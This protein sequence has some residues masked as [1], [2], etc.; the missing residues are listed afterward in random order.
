MNLRYRFL[1]TLTTIKL[2][3]I[4]L[5]FAIKYAIVHSYM[6]SHPEGQPD[7]V[8]RFKIMRPV[9][10]ELQKVRQERERW[11]IR[12]LVAEDGIK[13]LAEKVEG[14]AKENEELRN[15]RDG[16]RRRANF[17]ERVLLRYSP[18]QRAKRYLAASRI[19]S[20]REARE[21]RFSVRAGR[22]IDIYA[23]RA[24]TGVGTFISRVRTGLIRALEA[25]DSNQY[26]Q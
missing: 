25:E 26:I 7:E 1:S 5:T 24:F 13:Y 16:A 2:S 14:L 21:N 11:K 3:P 23:Q 10:L 4:V 9:D 8:L 17:A 18:E 19:A 22:A 15:Q 20:R 6:N 12:S